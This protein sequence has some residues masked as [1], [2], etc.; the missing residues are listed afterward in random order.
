MVLTLTIIYSLS[1]G[2]Y[3]LPMVFLVIILVLALLKKRYGED[4]GENMGK[5]GF[6]NT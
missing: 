6:K 2:D 5:T 4:L 1:T 3:V